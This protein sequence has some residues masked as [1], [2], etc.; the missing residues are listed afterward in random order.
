MSNN[1]NPVGF[2]RIHDAALTDDLGKETTTTTTRC[3]PLT[4]LNLDHR[5]AH[6]HLG[7]LIYKKKHYLRF[8][9]PEN[10]TLMEA[11]KKTKQN[12]KK[13]EPLLFVYHLSNLNYHL[14]GD[15]LLFLFC[16]II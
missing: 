12:E 9:I 15:L 14:S 11:S 13:I 16:Y 8:H 1:V 5:T 4:I 2:S 6:R 7:S 10:R 3:L